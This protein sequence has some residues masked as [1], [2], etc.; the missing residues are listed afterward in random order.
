MT[1][2]MIKSSGPKVVI[3]Y[4]TVR[5]NPA[6]VSHAGHF[7][8]SYR[9]H[10]PGFEHQLLVV[11]NGGRLSRQNEAIFAPVKHN[12][13][14]R[15]NDPG[16]DISAYIEAA[17]AMDSDLQVCL[18]ESVYFNR[19]GW[20]A[21]TVECWQK[22]GDGMYGYFSSYLVRP[23][24]NTTAFAVSPKYLLEYQPV[25]RDQKARYEFEH[26]TKALWRRIV[27]SGGTARLVTWDGCWEPQ[28]WRKPEN[29]LWK[30]TQSNCLMRC[31]HTDRF[32]AAPP[33]TRQRW[34]VGAD[35]LA[36]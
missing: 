17:K 7:V 29:V 25:P 10:P 23:H 4:I 8:D 27:E 9:C 31:N 21:R 2:E 5:D 11:C 12:M 34:Q 30:G 24:L 1:C 3:V 22:H 14:I 18:G 6:L 28:L 19:E 36:R 13:I 15:P 16:W 20:L 32:D 35:S 26:G 33:A